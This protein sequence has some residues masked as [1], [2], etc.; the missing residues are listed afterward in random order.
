HLTLQE[1]LTAQYIDDHRLVEK[2]VTE[3]LTDKRW[4]EVFLLVGGV[5]RGGAD[6]L[7]LLM[8]KEAQKYINTPK[9][10]GLLNWAEEVTVGSEGDYKP[11]GKRAVAIANANANAIAFTNANAI[12]ESIKYI[13]VVEKLKIYNQNLNLTAL[14]TELKTIKKN[15]TPDSNKTKKLHRNLAKNLIE[16]L[17]KSFNLTPEMVNLSKEEIKALENY[18]YA[19]YLIIQCQDAALSVSRETWEKIEGRMLLPPGN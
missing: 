19:N 15:N 4:K 10:Q 8:E 7:L 18:L 16:T 9:L 12:T 11:V 2:L 17:L 13:E 14:L 5:M 3:H 6:E 1:Y